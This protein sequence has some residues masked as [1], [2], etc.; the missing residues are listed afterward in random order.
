MTGKASRKTNKQLE[1][2]IRRKHPNDGDKLGR[3][4]ERKANVDCGES[5]EDIKR[6]RK[7]TRDLSNQF[8]AGTVQLAEVVLLINSYRKMRLHPKAL[9]KATTKRPNSMDLP[10]EKH[11]ILSESLHRQALQHSLNN[12][13]RE[14][15]GQSTDAPECIN[16]EY[17]S[18]PL[19]CYLHI[20]RYK[21]SLTIS[22]F[23][24]LADGSIVK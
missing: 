10:L 18:L 21:I 9:N 14:L 1:N 22:I 2:H 6:L 23:T 3:C 24:T 16:G 20:E 5:F 17:L 8:S 12:L 13:D 4:L 15:A 11:Q 19:L 7:D